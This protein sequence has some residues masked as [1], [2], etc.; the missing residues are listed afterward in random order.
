LSSWLFSR[1]KL[2][3]NK[4]GRVGAPPARLSRGSRKKKYLNVALWVCGRLEKY[5]AVGSVAR[6]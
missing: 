3:L 1:R 5:L 4:K 2:S 6:K